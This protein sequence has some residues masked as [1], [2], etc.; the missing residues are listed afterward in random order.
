MPEIWH[1]R[2][3]LYPICSMRRTI[4]IV[5][6][7]PDTI[8]GFFSSEAASALANLIEI[9]GFSKSAGL[10]IAGAAGSGG[11]GLWRLLGWLRG[12][13]IQRVESVDRDSVRI[14]VEGDELVVRKSLVTVLD[15]PGVRRAVFRV[16]DPLRSS[17]VDTFEIHDA[18]GDEINRIVSEELSFYDVH[19]VLDTLEF[20]TE[21]EYQK[22]FTLVSIAFE[23]GRKWRV[24]DGQ[25]AISVTVDDAGFLERID[26]HDV[27]F[28]KDD[29]LVCRVRETQT[30]GIGGLKTASRIVKVIDH[31]RAPS[32]TEL[33]FRPKSSG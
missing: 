24:T 2:W 21:I 28:A 8:V 1:R 31:R 17:G 27:L 11:Y 16:L 25:S 10:Y 18:A 7:L 3:S 15:N 20:A 19:T 26:N 23:E 30:H 4:N 29:I 32:Q 12:R 6:S 5:H 33:N 14:I 9:L 13:K 22:T